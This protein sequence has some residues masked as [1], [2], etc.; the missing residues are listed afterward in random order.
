MLSIK[1]WPETVASTTYNFNSN[2]FFCLFVASRIKIKREITKTE[3]LKKELYDLLLNT[4]KPKLTQNFWNQGRQA[5]AVLYM[6][7]FFSSSST[8][9]Y[10]M[11]SQ[12]YLESIKKSTMDLFFE[13][14]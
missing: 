13:N 5:S 1:I 3:L 6:L 8:N 11:D 10:L 2:W 12:K 4:C 14:S 9:L 7:G